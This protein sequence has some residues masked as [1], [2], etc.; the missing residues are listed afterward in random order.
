MKRQL[1]HNNSNELAI[2]FRDNPILCEFVKGILT[3]IDDDAKSFIINGAD[4]YFESLIDGLLLNYEVIEYLPK[5]I[6]GT[7]AIKVMRTYDKEIFSLGDKVYDAEYY[8]HNIARPIGRMY[9]E[10]DKVLKIRLDAN[11]GDTNSITW[12]SINSIS[13]TKPQPKSEDND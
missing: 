3:D 8:P 11:D 4:K 5:D 13:K 12:R 10:M 2:L 6:Y 1:M 7:A 9:Y